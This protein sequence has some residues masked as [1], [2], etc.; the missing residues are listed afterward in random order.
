[1]KILFVCTGNTCRSPMAEALMKS[2]CQDRNDIEISSCGLCAFSGDSA[3]AESIDAM[4]SYNIDLSEH[5]ARAFNIYMASE[6][7]LFCVMTESHAQAISQL[8]PRDKIVIL[9]GGIADPYGKSEEEYLLC[10]KQ[11]DTALDD[12]ISRLNKTEIVPMSEDDIQSIAEIEKECFA[13]PWSEDALKSELGNENA[14]FLAAKTDGQ[15]SGYIGVHT[16]LDESYIANVAVKG[17]FRRLGIG[18]ML[19]D[20]A[21]EK[22]RAKGCSF[23]SL[24]VRVSNAP[25]IRLYEKHGYVSQGERKNFYSHPTENALIMT[26]TFS[27]EG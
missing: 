21:E 9:G 3:S 22:V 10:A 27:E 11:I 8:V 16:V 2:K 24:E 13:D 19:L 15:V 5:R 4:K 25:A 14:V 18:S 12:I 1:M 23:I 6:Y 7:D 17:T 26:K 20:Y